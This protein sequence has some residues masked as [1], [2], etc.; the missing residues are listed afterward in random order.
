MTWQFL[1]DSQYNRLANCKSKKADILNISKCFMAE[2]H[3]DPEEAYISALE[4][5]GCNNQFIDLSAE[6]DAEII[7]KWKLLQHF[8]GQ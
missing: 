2:K 5:L 4:H 3:Q 7:R 6:E 8:R 1:T